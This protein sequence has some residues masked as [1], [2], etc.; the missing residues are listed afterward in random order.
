MTAAIGYAVKTADGIIDVKTVCPTPL[1]AKVNGLIGGGTLVLAGVS[2]EAISGVWEEH[3][4][5]TGSRIVKVEI[6][7]RAHDA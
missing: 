3:A 7:E 4:R 1:G 6:T 2:D 5:A